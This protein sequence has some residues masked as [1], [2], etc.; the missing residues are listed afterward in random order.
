MRRL[1]RFFA[2]GIPIGG[3]AAGCGQ[4]GDAGSAQGPAPT[5]ESIPAD[6]EMVFLKVEGMT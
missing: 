3:V 1:I 5:E 6:A 2:L 4:A